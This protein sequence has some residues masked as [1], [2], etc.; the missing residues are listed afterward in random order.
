MKKINAISTNETNIFWPK[1]KKSDV[2]NYSSGYS[3]QKKKGYRF[4]GVKYLSTG[5]RIWGYNNGN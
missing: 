2:Q 5:S 1:Y 4:L 3:V